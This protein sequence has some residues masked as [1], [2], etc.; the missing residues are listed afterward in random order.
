MFPVN[1]DRITRKEQPMRLTII[2]LLLILSTQPVLAQENICKA[3]DKT[4]LLN[5]L[6]ELTGT[7]EEKNW[8]DQTYR[9]IAKLMTRN[10]QVVEAIA[11]ISKIQNADTKAMTIRGI[12]MAAAESELNKQA[13]D[14][15]FSTLRS[16]AEKIDHPPSYAIALTYI[17][18]SQ[19]FAGDDEGAMKTASDMKNDALRNKAFAESAEIQAE[20]GRFDEAMK[21]INQI[22]SAS[23]RDKALKIVSKILAQDSEYEQ[24]LKFA[25]AVS[26]QYQKAQALLYIVSRQITPKEVSL[27]E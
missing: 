20:N 21:S 24:A 23:F 25:L 2:I 1:S 4:C 13:Y 19:A 22:D 3:T 12:G 11:L 5:S 15:L 6:D 7:I 10:N 16:E 27:V 18:M 8:K 9:E 26:D 14:E 17:A